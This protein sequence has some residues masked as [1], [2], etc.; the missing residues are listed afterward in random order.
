[1]KGIS[2]WLRDAA[3]EEG[4]ILSGPGNVHRDVFG[5]CLRWGRKA[6]RGPRSGLGL[7]DTCGFGVVGGCPGWKGDRDPITKAGLIL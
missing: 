2:T 1:M 7:E 5:P 3:E 6:R 4:L